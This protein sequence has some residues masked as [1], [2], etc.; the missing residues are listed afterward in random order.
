MR[1]NRLFDRCWEPKKAEIQQ[2]S[3]CTDNEEE[4][5]EETQLEAYENGE[6]RNLYE[7]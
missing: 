5:D 7:M 1:V 6:Y 4:H 2:R 3:L